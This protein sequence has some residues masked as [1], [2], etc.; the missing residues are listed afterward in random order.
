MNKRIVVDTSPLIAWEK[1]RALELIEK[2]PFDFICPAQVQTEILNGA[3]KGYSVNFP[4]WIKVLQ[5]KNPL[6][7]STP[8][9]LDDG[10]SAVIE[11]ALQR[12][13]SQVCLDEIKGRRAA[14]A[15]G[16]QVV[17]SLGIIGKVKTLGLVSA[18][19]PLIEKAQ[20]SGIYYDSKLVES[21]LKT[22]GE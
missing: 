7:I 3:A 20:S 8:A 4:V 22:F 12:G 1:M 11:L 10:E 14:A 5:L 16:L 6:T 15:S 19:R 18:L 21:F 2:L 13:I 17:G 9:N